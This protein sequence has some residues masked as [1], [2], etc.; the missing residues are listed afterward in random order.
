MKLPMEI[1]ARLFARMTAVAHSREPDFVI[2]GP[3]RPYLRRW[4]VVPRN[5][6]F[7]IYL[8]EFRRSDDDR[9]LHDHPWVNASILLCGAYI[10]HT[11]DAGGIHRRRCFRPG[12]IRLRLPSSAHRV[13]LI[14]GVPS[15]S[16]FLTGPRIREWG[17]HCPHA[18]WVHWRKF[19]AADDPGQVGPGCDGEA[20]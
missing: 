7:N 14:S 1:V 5:R 8:H 15:W 13:E 18:G 2:G 19:T 12:D 9:A 17:F 20:A 16:L 4:H 3:D 6:L 11:I 10:E